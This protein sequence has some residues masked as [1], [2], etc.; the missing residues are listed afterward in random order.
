MPIFSP[1]DGL[2]ISLEDKVVDHAPTK[3]SQYHFDGNHVTIRDS[4]GYLYVFVHNKQHSA[5][6][7]PGDPVT[8]GQKIAELGNTSST[9][10]HL[11][12][13]VWSEDWTVTIPVRFAQY[14]EITKHY[15]IVERKNTTPEQGT[16]IVR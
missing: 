4:R 5:W 6:V 8:A 14:S 9:V 2:V 1:V 7:K 13:G 12:F 3:E 16:V 11:H 10:P 15:G